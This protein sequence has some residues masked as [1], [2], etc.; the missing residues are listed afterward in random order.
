MASRSSSRGPLAWTTLVWGTLGALAFGA[1][2]ASAGN[3]Q[4]GRYQQKQALFAAFDAGSRSAALAVLPADADF[5]AMRYQPLRLE[6]RYDA[7]HQVLLD[8]AVVDGSVGYFVLTPFLTEAGTLLVNRGFVPAP[9][10][11]SQLP[12]VPVDGQPRVIAGIIDALPRP[13]LRLAEPDPGADAPWPRRIVYPDVAALAAM[14]GY[15]VRDFQL[16]LDPSAADGYLRRWRPSTMPPETH[17]GYAV[18][19]FGLLAAVVFVYFL[20]LWRYLRSRRP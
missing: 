15:P 14:L 6:G 9:P 18:Q 1:L 5:A 17:L 16:L 4:Y 19:W 2:F 3:W 7:E 8:N 10:E 13:G 11:R 20:L 12:E